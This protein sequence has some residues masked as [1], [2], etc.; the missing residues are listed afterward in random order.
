MSLTHFNDLQRN[1]KLKKR[2]LYRK[3]ISL[4]LLSALL[5]S[6]TS[7]LASEL[8]PDYTVEKVVVVYKNEDG[9][10]AVLQEGIGETNELETI[11]AVTTTLTESDI[12]KLEQDPNI[13]YVEEEIVFK[14]VGDFQTQAITSEESQWSFQA[15][16][17]NSQAFTD[18]YT[19]TGVKIAVIDTGIAAHTDLTIAGGVSTVDNTSSYH[20]DQGHGTHV[21]GI[22]GAKHNNVGIVGVAP[23]AQ[24]YSVKV[25]G[26]DG[27]GVSTDIVEGIDWAITNNMDII[28][29]SLGT[30]TESL[31]IK[32]A[33]NRATNEGILVVAASGNDSIRNKGARHHPIFGW[34]LALFLFYNIIRIHRSY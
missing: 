32:D 5:V 20:D 34:C 21:A 2:R 29:L 16:N 27:T 15:V 12:N 24:I 6:N 14:T 9:K 23:D 7:V 19:G 22:I 28:N 31:A 18:G 10:Q 4:G 25:L 3:V 1:K 8:A 17:E 30:D 33:V 26:A 13:A 11:S